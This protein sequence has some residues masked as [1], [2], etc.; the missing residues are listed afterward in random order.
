MEKGTQA[1]IER[2]TIMR[3]ALVFVLLVRMSIPAAFGEPYKPPEAYK[4][5]LAAFSPP[6]LAALVK[7]GTSIDGKEEEGAFGRGFAACSLLCD[8]HTAE[9]DAELKNLL[10]TYGLEPG[11]KQCALSSLGARGTKECVD[12]IA[13]FDEWARQVSLS[14]PPFR[15]DIGAYGR[16]GAVHGEGYLKNIGECVDP[17]GQQWTMLIH[18]FT[19]SGSQWITRHIKDKEWTNPMLV[20]TSANVPKPGTVFSGGPDTFTITTPPDKTQTFHLSE[21]LKDTDGDG[22]PD[23]LERALGTNPDVPDTDGDGKPDGKD[24]NPLTPLEHFN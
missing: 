2:I 15:V 22:S 18:P 3:A 10:L 5:E 1:R 20:S 12:I 19:F 8:A 23:V 21:A 9:A 16:N 13:E 11:V 4:P 7:N 6:E 14:P 24:G 17:S